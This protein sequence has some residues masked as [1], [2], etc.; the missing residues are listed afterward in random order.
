MGHLLL[1]FI[2]KW[3]RYIGIALCYNMKY[4]SQLNTD[5]VYWS[6]KNTLWMKC[7]GH[8]GHTCRT[9]T[10]IYEEATHDCTRMCIFSSAY[11]CAQ[12]SGNAHIWIS[13]TRGPLAIEDESWDV[14]MGLVSDSWPISHYCNVCYTMWCR[15]FCSKILTV[16]TS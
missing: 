7:A 4:R 3:Q 16:D 9:V 12:S 5:T 15:C 13:V 2:G 8:N 10:M 1:P 14:S 6:T 11:F